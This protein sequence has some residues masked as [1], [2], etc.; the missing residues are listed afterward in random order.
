[1]INRPINRPF[2]RPLSGRPTYINRTQNNKLLTQP[3]PT[4]NRANY[5]V[6]ESI[7]N[8]A[9]I[10]SIE[11]PS[12]FAAI[13]RPRSA[14][15]GKRSNS[16]GYSPLSQ[17]C[18]HFPEANVPAT[19][20]Q[21]YSE[22]RLKSLAQNLYEKYGKSNQRIVDLPLKANLTPSSFCIKELDIDEEFVLKSV[23][24]PKTIMILGATGSGKTTHIN[25]LFNYIVRTAWKAPYRFRLIS[26]ERN[27]NQATSQTSIITAYQIPRLVGSRLKYPV[28]IVDTTGFGDT[29]GIERDQAITEQIREFFNQ[30][31]F[32]NCI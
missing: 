30:A 2:H 26:E 8:I 11:G 29:R 4:L 5:R 9:P 6:L 3:L 18:C 21:N 22:R 16:M 31:K 7:P 10:T 19:D 20:R 15:P 28:T 24:T 27:A 23:I 32:Q 14:W 17:N 13:R 1:M 25:F 12:S